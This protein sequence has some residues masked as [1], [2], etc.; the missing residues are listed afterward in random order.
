MPSN[1]LVDHGIM[2]YGGPQRF[3]TGQ[4]GD[5][6]ETQ[7]AFHIMQFRPSHQLSGLILP[8]G[9]FDLSLFTILILIQQAFDGEYTS[10][11]TIQQRLSPA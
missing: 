10:P 9:E 11:G 5:C 7:A 3:V 4:A 8:Y 6:L 2:E 1:T